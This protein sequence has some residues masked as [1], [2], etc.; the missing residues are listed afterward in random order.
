[1][2]SIEKDPASGYYRIRFRFEGRQYQRSLRTKAKAEA[3]GVLARVQGTLR[4][5]ARGY[6]RVP[7]DA[8]AGL[9]IISDGRVAN[10]PKA[11]PATPTLGELF[12]HYFRHIA[13]G[14]KEE[15]TCDVPLVFKASKWTLFTIPVGR[16][17]HLW[18][19]DSSFL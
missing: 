1:M 3:D 6:L 9:F 15:S 14:A 12:Q 19:F 2:A 17:T 7:V 16:C 10:H 11:T 8:D 4:M 13:T 18:E 5:I